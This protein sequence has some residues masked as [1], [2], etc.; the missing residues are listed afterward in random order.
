MNRNDIPFELA[1]QELVCINN[2][3]LKRELTEGKTYYCESINDEG[4]IYVRSDY[5]A[6]L[7]TY[8]SRFVLKSEFEKYKE[9]ILDELLNGSPDDVFNPAHIRGKSP[10]ESLTLER[11]NKKP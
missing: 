7:L 4:L 3:H 2:K 9:K 11:Y 5:G 6:S 8:P 1:R 10:F